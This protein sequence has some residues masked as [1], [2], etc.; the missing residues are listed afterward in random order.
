[1]KPGLAAARAI[2]ADPSSQHVKPVSSAIQSSNLSLNPQPDPTGQNQLLLVLNIPPPTTESRNAAVSEAVKF[3]EKASMSIRDARG[4]QQKKL[5]AMQLNKA[6]RPDDLKKAST[7]ME[8]VVE[9]GSAELKKVVD[10][11][12]K[13][14]ESG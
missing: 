13:V 8:K 3:G 2:L 14:L 7:M 9:K 6:V 11:A 5:R 12:K 4:K 10:N 1:M